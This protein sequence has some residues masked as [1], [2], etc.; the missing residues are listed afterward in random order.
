MRVI[1]LHPD[2]FDVACQKLAASIHPFNPQVIIGILH[3][4]GE[5]G[6]RLA[7]HFP[8]ATYTEVALHRGNKAKK[9]TFKRLL[10]VLPT[11][12]ADMLRQ[13]EMKRVQRKPICSK[14]IELPTDVANILKSSQ[15]S[16]IL[17]VDDA[18]DSGATLKA[19]VEAVSRTASKAHIRSAVLTVTTSSPAISP[20]YALWRGDTL[21]RFP[22]S[23][24]YN[25]HRK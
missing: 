22:W 1:T 23:F 19:V 14:S 9:A 12:I 24:D 5:V 21:I 6:Q 16:N 4:G 3:G 25:T 7:A 13:M 2:D 17:I 11:S 8:E 18:V 20:D 10:R 15:L